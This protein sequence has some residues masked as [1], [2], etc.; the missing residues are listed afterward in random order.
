[1]AA[2][3]PAPAMA[4]L[5]ALGGATAAAKAMAA[6]ASAGASEKAIEPWTS[7]DGESANSSAPA[8]A[9]RCRTPAAPR[10]SQSG[11]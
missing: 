5:V 8:T 1:M 4:A 2:A 6:K 11:A 10:P 9:H 7:I 3:A